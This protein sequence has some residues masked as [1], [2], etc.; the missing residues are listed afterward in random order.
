MRNIGIVVLLVSFLAGCQT[1][2]VDIEA[3]SGSGPVRMSTGAYENYIAYIRGK[4]PLAFAL[5]EDG[6]FSFAVICDGYLCDTSKA[7]ADALRRCGELP[8]DSPCRLFAVGDDIVWGEPGDWRPWE[9]RPALEGD[10]LHSAIQA[11]LR[12]SPLFRFYEI[13]EGQKAFAAAISDTGVLMAR[14]QSGFEPS[15]QKAILAALR[16]CRK[17]DDE[18]AVNCRIVHLNGSYVGDMD[19]LELSRLG[20]QFIATDFPQKK[21]RRV[22]TLVDWE[23]V[24]MGVPGLLTY[25]VP[26]DE[27]SFIFETE[28]LGE[29]RCKGTLNFDSAKTAI[30]SMVCDDGRTANGRLVRTDHPLRYS[31]EGTDNE[32]GLIRFST[33]E[34][35]HS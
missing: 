21:L 32:G 16:H 24:G 6:V 34:A 31:G 27:G 14:G 5:S 15:V 4:P 30:W 35:P 26:R 9:G 18:T 28:A 2:S 17:W 13:V 8:H 7:P 29:H 19:P 10:A 12:N 3:A 25:H 33:T 20:D 11:D 23:G 1:T 22:S